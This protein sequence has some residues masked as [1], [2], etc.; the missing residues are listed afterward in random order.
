MFQQLKLISSF[1]FIVLSAYNRTLDNHTTDPQE[2]YYN[3]EA[4]SA[5]YT[6][7]WQLTLAMLVKGTLTIFTFGIQVG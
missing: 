1:L 2:Q 7:L 4:T 6:A 3:A 5:V